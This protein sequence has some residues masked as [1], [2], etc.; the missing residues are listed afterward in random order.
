MRIEQAC[1]LPGATADKVFQK[2]SYWELIRL[3]KY[4]GIWCMG[5]DEKTFNLASLRQMPCLLYFRIALL[6]VS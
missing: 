2:S 1:S 5:V 3:R 6:A 4:R